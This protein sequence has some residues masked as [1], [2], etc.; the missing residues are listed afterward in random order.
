MCQTS[1]YFVV[2]DISTVVE[3]ESVFLSFVATMR[4][5][6][7]E[8]GCAGCFVVGMSWNV[9]FLGNWES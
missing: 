2:R 3:D 5:W 9:E 6:Y 4:Y 8:E 7:K 1:P